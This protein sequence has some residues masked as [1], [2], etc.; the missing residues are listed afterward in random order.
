ME[1]VVA[2]AFTGE[3]SP[4]MEWR[5]H[6]HQ[7]E[8]RYV[9]CHVAPLLDRDGVIIAGICTCTDITARRCMEQELRVS[10]ARLSEVQR[11]TRM[12]SWEFDVR[13]WEQIWSEEMYH[14]FEI[15]PAQSPMDYNSYLQ[16]IHPEDRDYLHRSVL[17]AIE[18][19]IE[20]EFD[21][22]LLLPDGSEKILHCTGHPVFNA[23][24]EVVRVVGT[25]QD[26]THCRWLERHYDEQ[27]TQ[28][29]EAR[30]EL[31]YKN[32]VLEGLATT[33]GL[34]GLKNHR[35]FQEQLER[36][37]LRASRYQ[38]PLSLL[39]LDVDLF[40]SY[41]DTFGHLRGDEVLQRVAQILQETSRKSDCVARY[42]G[43]EFV[44]ILPDTDQEAAL[45]AGERLCHAIEASSWSHRP[46]TASFGV[47]TFSLRTENWAQLIAE[48]DA[49]LYVSKKAGRN[50]VTH[51]VDLVV[52]LSSGLL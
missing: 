41:N 31:E 15:D 16:R 18:E 45:Q 3:R 47:S 48:A 12:G 23:A 34:T 52:P 28:L 10:E 22:R 1:T 42:G 43:E 46:I 39:L 2:G 8:V 9:L 32:A 33:D 38:R 20:Y 13:T 7:G 40:K 25:G 30:V 24:Q 6:S 29:A 44:V 4:A 35:A 19:G 49:A 51:F 11:L 21:H 5:S 36:E 14:I 26:V 50:R 27:V 17:L 37:F